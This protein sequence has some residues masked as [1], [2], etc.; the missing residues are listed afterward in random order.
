MEIL[1]ALTGTQ[2]R[3]TCQTFGLVDAVVFEVKKDQL[4]IILM[5]IIVEVRGD[6]KLTEILADLI[7]EDFINDLITSIFSVIFVFCSRVH[8]KIKIII[9]SYLYI[10]KFP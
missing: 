3:P 5:V 7:E 6:K 1:T 2:T 10:V 9:K 4:L 8:N